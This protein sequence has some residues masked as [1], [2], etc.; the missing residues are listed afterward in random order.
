[1]N[2]TQ[3]IYDRTS[4]QKTEYIGI[5]ASGVDTDAEQWQIIEI[6]YDDDGKPLTEKNAGGSADYKFAWSDRT[7][8][9][10]S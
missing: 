6:T 8:L 4:T 9:E 1:M 7:T 5:A 10:Y 3:K 2:G